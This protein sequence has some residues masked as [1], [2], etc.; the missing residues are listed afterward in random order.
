MSDDLA[1]RPPGPEETRGSVAGGRGRRPNQL[2]E[3]M[4]SPRFWLVFIAV[5]LLNWFLAP[6]LFPE[7]QDRVTVPYTVFVAQVQGDNVSE[8][9]SRADRVQGTFKN[10]IPD[11]SAE[12][13]KTPRMITRFDSYLPTFVDSARLSAQ[14]QDHNVQINAQPLE[15]PR[16]ALLNL[17]IAF[18]PT[19]LLIGGFLWIMSRTAA[20]GAATRLAAT[21]SASK[22]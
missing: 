2:R 10:P 17:L 12:T 8:I 11:P 4:R 20:A 21:T 9:T 3:T 18:G 16:S 19:V 22:H 7:P 13:G 15:E 1:R 5:A 6:L 14:L